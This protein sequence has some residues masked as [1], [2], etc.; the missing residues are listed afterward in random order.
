L[1]V[2][3]KALALSSFDAPP[4]VIEV[5]DPIVQAGEVLVRVAAASLNPYDAFVASGAAKAYMEYEFPAVLGGNL[6]GTVE[7][8]GDGV[9]R[10][11]VGDRVF[12][13]MGA[14]GSVHDGSIAELATP[15]AGAIARTPDG[16]SDT[17]ASTLG[18]AG[19]TAVDAIEAVRPD[20]GQR[21]LIVG[22]TGGIGSFAI[23]LARLRGADVIAT[24]RPGDEGFVTD[25]GAT[26]TVDYTG[27]V[28]ET[29]RERHPDGVAAV[30]DA[31]S[32]GAD[33]FQRIVG[34]VRKGGRAAST[35]GAAQ[36]D[37]IDGVTVANAN[38]NPAHLMV[39]AE[40]V[41]EGKVRVAVT[42]TFALDDAARGLGELNE[43]HTLGKLVVT[44]G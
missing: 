11:A 2:A 27:D 14:K 1:E 6:A 43:Q 3:M 4:A 44:I 31:V 22:A 25:L 35:R 19:T 38:G 7:A 33:E 41:A 32:G 13:M 40:L 17:D 9:D 23:Q 28:A 42:R 20:D 37:E 36:G 5:R 18:V 26:E 34:L 16:V 29:I 8:L 10:F 30:I 24:V 12:G 39:L 21:V 15:Q